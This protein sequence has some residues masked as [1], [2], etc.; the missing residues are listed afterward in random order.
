M[1]FSVFSVLLSE[2]QC[3]DLIPRMDPGRC[4][5]GRVDPFHFHAVPD[6]SRQ[7]DRILRPISVSDF[8]I[9]GRVDKAEI[10][11]NER[12]GKGASD[13]APVIVDLG[14]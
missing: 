13:H 6:P 12:K 14:D 5:V 9:A 4:C 7:V 10:D 11:R 3:K 2:S 1:P 8:H